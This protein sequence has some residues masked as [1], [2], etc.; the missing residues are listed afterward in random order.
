MYLSINLVTFT[1]FNIIVMQKRILIGLSL[2]TLFLSCEKDPDK[3]NDFSVNFIQQNENTSVVGTG[4]LCNLNIEGLSEDSDSVSAFYSVEGG[5]GNI[6][7]NKKYYKENE[8][9][10]FKSFDKKNFSFLYLPKSEGNHNL[11]FYIKKQS[12]GHII[13]HSASINLN[14]SGLSA[15]IYGLDSEV[16]MGNTTQFHLLI[17]VDMDVFCKAVF[18]KGKGDIEIMNSDIVKNKV[19]LHNDNEVLLTPNSIGECRVELEISGIY[20]QP[21][22]NIVVI[23]VVK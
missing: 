14:I 17:D 5:I 6:L 4:I 16:V 1:A 9:F 10:N 12:K 19:L 20:G 18:L 11:G 15:K 21:I 23:N 7:I 3:L 22:R 8:E 13:E 2:I